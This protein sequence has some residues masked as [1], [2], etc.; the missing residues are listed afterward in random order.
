[1]KWRHEMDKIRRKDGVETRARIL[2]VAGRLFAEK[3]FRNT[4]HEE[5]CR[6]A[7]VN[8]GAI[9]YHFRSKENLYVEAWKMAFRQSL[10]KHPVDGGVPPGTPP[11]ER[12]R[13]RILSFMR[14]MSDPENIEFEIV[15]KE[16]ATPTGFLA[17]AMRESLDPLRKETQS[18]VRELLGGKA[19]EKD[20]QLCEMSIMGQ[21][22]NP[23][24]LHKRR[25]GQN[26][27][28]FGPKPLDFDIETIADHVVSFSLAGIREMRKRAGKGG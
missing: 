15:H 21:C 12:F 27:N 3:G 22:F 24:V 13:G 11:E 6:L 26:K 28:R 10:E 2:E 16:M 18:L 5:I 20:V 9:N 25:K 23:A 4:I 14:R 7:D 1:L 17:G 19:T 8:I